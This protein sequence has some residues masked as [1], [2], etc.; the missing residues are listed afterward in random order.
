MS[1]ADASRVTLEDLEFDGT[2]EVTG[3]ALTAREQAR[4]QAAAS[5][6]SKLCDRLTLV[7]RAG[8]GE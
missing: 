8:D 1:I 2:N 4:L 6:L 5:I 7:G 3:T